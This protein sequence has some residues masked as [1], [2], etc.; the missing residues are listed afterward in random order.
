MTAVTLSLVAC[1]DTGPKQGLGTLLGAGGGALLGSQLGHGRGTLVGVGAGALLGALIGSEVGKSL[2]KADR[3][4]MALANQR[5]LETLPPGQ[6]LPWRNPD[7]GNSGTVTP[8]AYF[9]TENGGYCREF[10]QTITVGGQTQQG[11]GTACRQS[12]G[13]WKIQ[14]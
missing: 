5:A 2:D 10:Q 4:H 12:D 6:S 8:K 3:D 14:S 11:Y 7:S 13:S 1:E 9:R